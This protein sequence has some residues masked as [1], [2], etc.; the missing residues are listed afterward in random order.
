[1]AA[2]SKSSS[3]N[4]N[5]NAALADMINAALAAHK[6]GEVESALSLYSK[7]YPLVSEVNSQLASTIASNAGAI[8]NQIGDY[9][10]SKD[11]FMKAV[12]SAP[13]S[14]TARFNLAVLLT[15]KFGNHAEALKHTVKVL[16]LQPDLSKVHHLM[17]NILQSLGKDAEAEKYFIRA[18]ELALEQ[19]QQRQGGSG[20]API[21]TESGKKEERE[22]LTNHE[23]TW[24]EMLPILNAKT[25]DR[26]SIPSTVSDIVYDIECLSSRPLLFRV[27]NLLSKPEC[28][29]IMSRAS[30]RLEKSVVMGGSVNGNNDS[31][32]R[33]SDNAWL[34]SDATLLDIQSRIASILS[35]PLA[36]IRTKAEDL[37]VVRYN[38]G[39]V[40]KAHHDSSAFHPRLFTALVYLNSV[41]A[42]VG[43]ETYFPFANSTTYTFIRS[44]QQQQQQLTQQSSS[45]SSTEITNDCT[46]TS[47]SHRQ[48]T[49]NI[50][51]VDEA[52]AEALSIS[53][54]NDNS[55]YN[56]NDSDSK[57]H[58]K[59]IKSDVTNRGFTDKGIAVTP[60]Q[61]DCIIFFNHLPV[62]SSDDKPVGIQADDH[63]E[64]DASAVHAGMTLKRNRDKGEGEGGREGEGGAVEKWVAN[65]W[66]ELDEKLLRE[67]LVNSRT[68]KNGD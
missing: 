28:E 63:W 61:G 64:I 66:V 19:Q 37:Q 39:G 56:S 49:T 47:S 58:S 9:D 42:G 38:E 7:V 27:L 11:F 12:E 2:S 16:K 53:T 67:A 35:V 52:I 32:Y 68:K 26:I 25:G 57:N 29:H 31:P 20:G 15:S 3:S 48:L 45:L 62:V 50:G 14:A 51:S 5:S 8:C 46:Q 18:E 13:D 40:F 30:E 60:V 23:R 44:Q 4:T 1:M 6:A 36:Y 34:H 24:Q 59:S 55:S 33:T 17:G 21:V 43:G 10:M 22:G 65:Y 54:S 41:P